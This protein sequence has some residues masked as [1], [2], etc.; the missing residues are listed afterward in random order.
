MNSLLNRS[1]S[2][3]KPS[4]MP[5]VTAAHVG[6]TVDLQIHFPDDSQP[7]PNIASPYAGNYQFLLKAI[8]SDNGVKTETIPLNFSYIDLREREQ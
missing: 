2:A 4:V 8:P 3:N 6:D 7:Q 5:V 1:T